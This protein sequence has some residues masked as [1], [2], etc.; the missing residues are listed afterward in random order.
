MSTETTAKPIGTAP[1]ELETLDLEIDG[2]IGTLT[3]TGPSR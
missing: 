1:P 3:L 2:E